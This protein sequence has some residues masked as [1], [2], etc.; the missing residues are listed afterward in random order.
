MS[1]FLNED[2]LQNRR[3][4]ECNWFTHHNWSDEDDM[5]LVGEAFEAGWAEA[6]EE[7]KKQL[8]DMGALVAEPGRW[9]RC[10]DADGSLWCESSNETEVRESARPGDSIWRM[11]VYSAATPE[12]R[13]VDNS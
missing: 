1:D 7:V 12:W 10:T 2:E 5:R 13:E 8:D 11:W 6:V 4:S 9:W 3:E